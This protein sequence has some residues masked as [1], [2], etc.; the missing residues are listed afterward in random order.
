MP[1][2]MSSS[3]ARTSG[4]HPG[5]ELL[6]PLRGGLEKVFGDTQTTRA[7]RALGCVWREGGWHSWVGKK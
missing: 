5:G 1:W 4:R 3:V 6:G 2:N 7:G